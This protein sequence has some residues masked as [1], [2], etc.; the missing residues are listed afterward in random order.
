L[1]HHLLMLVQK[2]LAAS[3]SVQVTEQALAPVL[4]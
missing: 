1:Q 4:V 2:V 3:R